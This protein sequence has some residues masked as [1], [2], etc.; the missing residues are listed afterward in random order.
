MLSN[1]DIDHVFDEHR[2]RFYDKALELIQILFDH[3]QRINGLHTLVLLK[4]VTRKPDKGFY[5][6]RFV[7]HACIHQRLDDVIRAAVIDDDQIEARHDDSAAAVSQ[8]AARPCRLEQLRWPYEEHDVLPETTSFAKYWDF[9]SAVR[10]LRTAYLDQPCICQRH[11]D[12][13]S[14]DC[15][16]THRGMKN[17]CFRTSSIAFLGWLQIA[18]WS[19]I[20]WNVYSTLG[21]LFAPEL[22]ERIFEC[23]LEVEGVPLDPATEEAITASPPPSIVETLQARA[24]KNEVPQA[25]LWKRAKPTYR[26]CHLE[27]PPPRELF[28]DNKVRSR[29]ERRRFEY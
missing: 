18:A 24:Q 10:S 28:T 13:L 15:W 20:R 25:A 19:E 16:R 26:C 27:R 11:R 1:V 4:A 23:A 12:L 3:G 5:R 29:F 6:G 8:Q 14:T 2:W 22:T 21:Q 9:A 7:D 17:R